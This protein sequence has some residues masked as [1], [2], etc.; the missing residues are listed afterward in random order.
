MLSMVCVQGRG[1]APSRWA[2]RLRGLACRT[3]GPAG[4]QLT[5]QAGWR[6][7]V[8]GAGLRGRGLALP[9]LSPP[10]CALSAAFVAGPACV[11]LTLLL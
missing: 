11:M 7:R 6:P 4:L 10:P 9:E 3:R 2:P 1:Q 8:E 5:S